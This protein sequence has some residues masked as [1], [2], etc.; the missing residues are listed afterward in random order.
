MRW[1]GPWCFRTSSEEEHG[2][3]GGAQGV[4]EGARM[5]S[6]LAR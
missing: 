3:V 2:R 6:R 1:L 4:V 5:R